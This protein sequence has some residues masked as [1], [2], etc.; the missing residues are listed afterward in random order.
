MSAPLLR[1]EL[2]VRGWSP[3][4]LD[5][6]VRE[7]R[8]LRLRRGA[9]AWAGDEQSPEATHA[10]LVA[11]TW[12]QLRVPGTISHVSA[13]VPHGLPLWA[14]QL[15]RVHLTRPR[16]GGGKSR[17]VLRI[18][19]STL[20]A[21]EVVEVAGLSVTSRGRTVADLGRSLPL[22]QA[23]A[24][25]DAAVRS[26]LDPADLDAVLGHCAGWP[27]VA[28]A[29]LVARWADSRSESAGES[30]SR[31]R[32][33]QAG[34]PAPEPQLVVHD[35]RGRFVARCDFGWPEQRVVGEFDGRSKYG[36][37][38]RPGQDLAEVLHREKLREDSLR[39]LGWRVVRWTWPDLYP[40]AVLVDR[41][42]RALRV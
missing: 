4:D 42:S 16:T 24:A 17:S 5:R 14:E 6:L 1:P 25:A 33:H 32:M 26:G 12:S 40:G 20:R 38:L 28:R 10:L 41:L 18:H 35:D 37:L 19:S 13:A 31:V 39:D 36:R 27:G 22:E 21:D 9:Y 7:A 29:L 15:G 3:A 2:L 11:A 23:V 34:L 30:V 8:L